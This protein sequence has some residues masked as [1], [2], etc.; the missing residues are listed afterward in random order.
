MVGCGVRG[1]LAPVGGP[2]SPVCVAFRG[3]RGVL[4]QALPA[5]GPGCGASRVRGLGVGESLSQLCCW[6]SR[7]ALDR[8]P[9]TIP[10]SPG[11]P[12]GLVYCGM[13]FRGFSVCVLLRSECLSPPL[14]NSCAGILP[15]Q[16]GG[17][18][19][20]GIQEGF[21]LLRSRAREGLGVPVRVPGEL[22]SFCCLPCEVTAVCQPGSRTS[23]HQ[24]CLPQP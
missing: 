12:A 23:R 7:E 8:V 11:L 4:G 13:E 24:T 17:I 2:G 10:A 3:P 18:R 19:G 15:P 20:S 21:G 1:A 14:P 9:L 22:A 5:P 6:E 16:C